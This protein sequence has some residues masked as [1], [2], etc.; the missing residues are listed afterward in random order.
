M[1]NTRFTQTARFWIYVNNDLV[2]ISMR[3]D[4]VLEWYSWERTEEGWA[5][6]SLSLEYDA[7]SG[8]VFKTFESAG[9]DCDGTIRNTYCWSCWLHLLQ[10]GQENYDLVTDKNWQVITFPDWIETKSPVRYDEY[11]VKAGY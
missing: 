4:Q 6:Q 1:P 3:P 9:R 8:L 11:A 7:H 2:K 5:S 10:L